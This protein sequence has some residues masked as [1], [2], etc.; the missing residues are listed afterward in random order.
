M[1][2]FVTG[3]KIKEY[4][5]ML[6]KISGEKC[7]L[8]MGGMDNIHK[9]HAAGLIRESTKRPVVIVCADEQSADN[10]SRDIE[11]FTG[12][13]VQK[14]A[15]R[16]FTFYNAESVSR[17]TEQ[18]RI[19]ALY[20]MAAGK[21]PI[22]VA[23]AD[24]LMQ[25]SIPRDILKGGAFTLQTGK[26]YKLEEIRGLFVSAGYR[27]AQQVEGTGQF[28]VRGGILDFYSP[29]SSLPVRCE[30][31]GDEID[32]MAYFDT[33]T[34]RRLD[35]ISGAEILPTAESLASLCPGGE[36]E[37]C[38]KLEELA[39]KA[40]GIKNPELVRNLEA[41]IERIE[42]GRGFY[43][44]DKYMELIYDKF[45]TAVDYISGS[46]VIVLSEPA[47]LTG[48]G[49]NYLWQFQEDI[50]AVFEAGTMEGSIARL[51]R[52][53]PDICRN[54]EK[55]TLIMMEDFISGGKEI[56]PVSSFSISAKRL[57]AYG[58]SVE[59]AEGDI[60]HYTGTGFSVV[61]LCGDR[62]RGDILTERLRT[63][64]I[65]ASF[66]A[67]LLS[68]PPAGRCMVTVGELSC[69]FEYP[70]ARLA[71]IT[72]GQIIRNTAVTGRGKRARRGQSLT[73]YADLSPGDLVVHERSGIGRFVGIFPMDIDGAKKD[74]IKIAYRG[75]DSLYVPA[76]QLDMVSK[77]IGG[78]EGHAIKL[79]KMG[80]TDWTRAKT[81]AKGA[82][83]ELARE[84]TELYARRQREAGFAFPRD[85]T[86]QAEFEGAF[87]YAETED[88]LT[89][90]REVKRDMEKKMPMD[91]L[92][93]GD[94]GYGKTEV[95]LRAVM[96]CVLAGKQAAMLVPTTVLA[97]QHYNTVTRRFAGY[98]VKIELLSRFRTAAEMKK[99]LRDIKNGSVDI[100]I[101]TH[102]LI[103]KSVAFKDL[104]LLIVDEEQR[105]G[106]SHKERL[107]EMS[108]NVDVLT[109]S[110]TPIPR[111]LNMALSGI[112]DMSTIEEPPAGRHPVQTYVLEHDWAIIADAVRREVARGGQVYY[113]HNRVETI[114]RA[115]SRVAALAEGIRIGVAHGKM[116][117]PELEAVMERMAEGEIQALVCTTIIESGL[118]IANVNTLIIEDA[119]RL[120]LAQLHQIRGRVG[121]SSRHA[122][123]Y[124]TYRQGKVLTEVAAKRLSAIRE[125]AE[126]NSGF[127]IAMRDLEIRGAGN[128]L[129]AEQ[130]GHMIS[131]GYDM[132]LKLLN[133]AV[134]EEKG[135][136]QK[137][138]TDC[139]A[140]LSISANIPEKYMPS[141][142]QR[143]DIYRR[144]AQIRTQEDAR[145]L[146][147]ELIDRF[148]EPP[149]S[150]NSLVQVSLL[151]G[152]ASRIGITEIS[153]KSGWVHF[154]LSEFDMERISEVYGLPEFKGRVK[155][156]AGDIPVIRLKIRGGERETEEA[157]R[158]LTAYGKINS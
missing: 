67:K 41:D 48:R 139:S 53:W 154:T 91:R 30:F 141:P 151:R 29:G 153:Q 76:T 23:T 117:E 95:A 125:F 22:V 12:E 44:A 127:K 94:V 73:S 107:K 85:A 90:I 93:C 72:E 158:F 13:T 92:L 62:R 27:A 108:K 138:R 68:I 89:S 142:E 77:Y 46:A 45:E 54:L 116:D 47:R 33:D 43:A 7:P 87:E 17:Q 88:Q 56:S 20:N 71:V 119:D 134:L 99:A 79:S 50:K 51:C 98:P 21:A 40:A 61:V 136:R 78:G 130:S 35:T 157:M 28:A 65:S 63:A 9:A 18:E 113:L 1:K 59:T 58:G 52:S 131:V 100:V 156:M 126:F 132:Y 66:D 102:K 69:G 96:K 82:A 38:R 143:M 97:Q 106:V 14:L 128:L 150:V 70:G 6:D 11:S 115:A 148:G 8:L 2:A 112:R 37:L 24:G 152:V 36:E 49:K 5:E 3:L 101:G 34:Q 15:S 110:A 129:G 118:D 103:Q 64:G 32:S 122:F 145:D 120:G 137:P 135:D 133:E 55:F 83:K 86:W 16:E 140:D 104:G 109:L 19:A 60:K 144:I 75:T 84:L 146:T 123:A 147:D 25:R 26:A 105:F 149:E 42:N 57:P 31:W 124:L 80:G 10:M 114:E 39:R 121:R 4:A 155:I 111:T 74:Y 81:R